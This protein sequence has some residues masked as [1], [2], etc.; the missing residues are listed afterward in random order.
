MEFNGNCGQFK[1]RDK[2]QK[3]IQNTM[4]VN[5]TQAK[6]VETWSSR[7]LLSNATS[8]TLSRFVMTWTIVYFDDYTNTGRLEDRKKKNKKKK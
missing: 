7:H 1:W 8:A 6:F 2:T 5:S 3:S 4:L